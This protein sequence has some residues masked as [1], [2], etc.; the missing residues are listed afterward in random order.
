MCNA[1][2]SNRK[3]S[4][5]STRNGSIDE[6]NIHVHFYSNKRLL[7][8]LSYVFI[9]VLWAGHIDDAMPPGDCTETDAQVAKG[10]FFF[11]IISSVVFQHLW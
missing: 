4:G 9:F 6:A 11:C 2:S 5:N 1:A 8:L 10:F 3:P 7:Y